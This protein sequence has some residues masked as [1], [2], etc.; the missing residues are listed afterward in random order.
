MP[1]LHP[2][3]P[4]KLQYTIRV[5]ADFFP[6]SDNPLS[7]DFGE[8]TSYD[9]LITTT[10]PLRTHLITTTQSPA[11]QQQT[12]ATLRQIS[13]LDDQLAT[14]IQSI[15]H[16]KARHQFFKSFAKDPIAFLRRWSSSQ[17]HDLAVLLGEVE[18]WDVGGLEFARGGKDGV[19]GD[20]P[21]G[22]GTQEGVEGGLVGREGVIREIVRGRL[23]R[24]GVGAR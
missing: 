20:R 2:L 13:S 9:I 19:W 24:E 18:R 10:D 4:L 6:T 7:S 3:T 5:D 16:H 1:H 15:S 14:L 21:Y 12:L 11:H 23:G 17:S 8:P 22:N